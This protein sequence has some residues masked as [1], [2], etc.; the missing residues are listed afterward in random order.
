MHRTVVPKKEIACGATLL[1]AFGLSWLAPTLPDFR[2]RLL[3]NPTA[4]IPIEF[5]H[6]ILVDSHQDAV[7]RGE[8]PPVLSSNALNYVTFRNVRTVAIGI[9]FG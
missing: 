7:I 8:V 6:Y 5:Y 4:A 2:G 1:Q 3:R 9:E